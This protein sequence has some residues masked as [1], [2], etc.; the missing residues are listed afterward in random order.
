MVGDHFLVTPALHIGRNVAPLS[1][2]KK[3]NQLFKHLFILGDLLESILSMISLTPCLTFSCT[4][5][6]LG[7]LTA[8]L[9]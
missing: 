4:H 1:D 3:K 5:P 9:I 6:Y 8:T 7:S 2:L